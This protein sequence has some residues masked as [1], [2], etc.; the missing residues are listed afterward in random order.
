[1]NIPEEQAFYA[2]DL[3]VGFC[4]TSS[5]ERKE[6]LTTYKTTLPNKKKNL[7]P[8]DIGEIQL[9]A[10]KFPGVIHQCF[11]ELRSQTCIF[12]CFTCMGQN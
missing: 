4:I 7:T 2:A 10:L 3:E 12:A 6:R 9:S 8:G 5:L 1:V 11:S